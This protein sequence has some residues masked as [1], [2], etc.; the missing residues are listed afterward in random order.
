MIILL[1]IV[2]IVR[3]T[4]PELQPMAVQDRC[5]V[6][7]T[8]IAWPVYHFS[9]AVPLSTDLFNLLHVN[10]IQSEVKRSF[11]QGKNYKNKDL[12]KLQQINKIKVPTVDIE[13]MQSWLWISNTKVPSF[14][15][16]LLMII[17][18]WFQVMY[19]E[20]LNNEYIGR[21]YRMSSWYFFNEFLLYYVNF[22]ICEN[23]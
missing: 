17:S 6:M 8:E 23:K 14:D 13:I 20:T 22:S 5:H 21:I 11:D 15:L 1:H 19:S 7:Q 2:R 4:S 16:I 3:I 10:P 9:F 18:T 12:E